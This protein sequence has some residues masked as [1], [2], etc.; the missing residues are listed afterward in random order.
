[1]A[2]S[3]TTPAS[4]RRKIRKGT[5]S[6]WDCKRRKVR[7][8]LVDH[9]N[10]VCSACRKRGTKCV[11]QDV[12]EALEDDPRVSP[13]NDHT[14]I[15]NDAGDSTPSQHLN[16]P[17]ATTT[18]ASTPHTN[19]TPTNN[20]TFVL[21]S[22]NGEP[23]NAPN[24]HA[25]IC[26]EL[27]ASLPPQ[28]DIDLLCE[29]GAHVSILLHFLITSPHLQDGTD[30]F[31]KLQD[32]PTVNSHP[33]Q[34]VTYLLLAT[35]ALQHLRFKES[36]W[37]I[38]RLSEVSQFFMMRLVDVATRLVTTNDSLVGSS[39]EGLESVMMEGA[40]HLNRGNLRPAWVAFRRAIGLAQLLGIHRPGHVPPRSLDPQHK[41]D[42]AYL[43]HRL[44][45]SDRMLCLLMGLPQASM[46]RSMKDSTNDPVCRL[47]HAHN[48]IA[49]RILERHDANPG[50][51]SIST[52]QDID[53][54]LQ[55]AAEMMPSEWWAMP[56][57]AAA[58]STS[59]PPSIV[60]EMRRLTTQ[61]AHYALI[62]YLHIPLMLNFT[63]T[64][65]SLHAYSQSSCI[66]ASREILSRHNIL[67]A[68]NRIAYSC[69]LVDLFSLSAS[70]LLLIAHLQ[71]HAR[72][73]DLG[74]FNPLLHQRQT[75]RAMVEQS[76]KD[77]QAISWVNID[78]LTAN[79]ADLLEKLLAIEA[80]AKAGV[81]RYTA[82][83][84]R[85]PEENGTANGGIPEESHTS[86]RA[87]NP[88]LRF[89]IPYFGSVRIAPDGSLSKEMR[90]EAPDMSELINPQL[91]ESGN[92]H[93]QDSASQGVPWYSLPSLTSVDNL[94][95]QGW[96][97]TFFDR[98]SGN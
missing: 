34:I 53:N 40:Y 4:K 91:Y 74:E 44:V 51:F 49:S 43:W 59:K 13:E 97:M 20:S 78:S 17:A 5:T 14:P 67:R 68:F 2:P 57:L 18:T 26:E 81:R 15:V 85:D 21:F 56:N 72:T 16:A 47:E 24:P 54:E 71:Q 88:G 84:V 32:R 33:V 48:V 42:T 23:P 96:D 50:S 89:C 63:T 52:F 19:E 77:L 93:T 80:E 10:T 31:E 82:S 86:T 12:P 22:G 3:D 79:A 95:F 25:K 55:K 28:K 65:A 35:A 94:I 73:R 8:S 38:A 41:C 7:C 9:P 61:V 6:C 98:M 66:T 60:H 87:E 83:S 62:N 70:L 69:R 46:D 29:A 36:G 37:Q 11:T 1:M 39:V 75:D 27:Y 92:G 30:V 76:V 58:N 64:N 45:Y 90:N